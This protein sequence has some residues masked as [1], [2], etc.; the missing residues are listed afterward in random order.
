MISAE[1][2]SRPRATLPGNDATHLTPATL[3]EVPRYAGSRD[4]PVPCPLA[5]VEETRIGDNSPTLSVCQVSL[6]DRSHHIV[7][8]P[9]SAACTSS[10]VRSLNSA[11]AVLL[12][13]FV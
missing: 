1:A 9:W 13:C 7:L 3:S 5:E 12:D 11:T 4:N 8:A 2:R 10:A 6:T